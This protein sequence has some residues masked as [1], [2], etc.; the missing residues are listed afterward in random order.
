MVDYEDF[1]VFEWLLFV[2]I[3]APENPLDGHGSHMIITYKVITVNS[4]F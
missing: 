1:D 3:F 2:F 4:N